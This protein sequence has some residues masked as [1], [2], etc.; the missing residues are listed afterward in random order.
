MS[1]YLVT[2][3]I[4]VY[5]MITHSHSVSLGWASCDSD[6]HHVVT[7]GP[8]SGLSLRRCWLSCWCRYGDF[9]QSIT[10]FVSHLRYWV[11]P[12]IRGS[13]GTV[14]KNWSSSPLN[15][16]IVQPVKFL[17]RGGRTLNKRGPFIGRAA[18]R[19]S[20]IDDGAL[21]MMGGTEHLRPCLA[22][23]WLS[24]GVLSKLGTCSS[25]ILHV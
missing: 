8:S 3:T 24:M 5:C 19:M 25:I 17:I 14:D 4:F 2:H 15:L 9:V 6:G 1:T 13:S 16:S 23:Q 18:N 11:R 12:G 20:L 7:A 22:F 21:D 10:E